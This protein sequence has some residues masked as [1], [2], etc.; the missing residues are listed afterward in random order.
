MRIHF[1][2]LSGQGID[3][4]TIQD[5]APLDLKPLLWRER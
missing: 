2:L 1:A 5:M 3:E 4:L